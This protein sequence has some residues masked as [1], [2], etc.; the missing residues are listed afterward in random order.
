MVMPDAR[1]GFPCP[2]CGFELQGFE[3]FCPACGSPFALEIEEGRRARVV[4]DPV[5][6]A[7][8]F[9]DVRRSFAGKLD[10]RGVI[11]GGERSVVYLASDLR[12]DC[13]VALKVLRPNLVGTEFG[14]RFLREIEITQ[15]LHH[16]GVMMV[17]DMGT[18]PS[19]TDTATTYVYF[20]LQYVQ[21]ETLR[22]RLRRE[23]QLPVDEA[24]RIVRELAGALHYAH[25][26]QV[27]HRDVKPDNV[28]LTADGRVLLS[29]FGVA[30]GVEASTNSRLTGEGFILGTAAYLSP[31]AIAGDKQDAR[32][33]QYSLAC[34]L[35]ECLVGEAPF[36]G[37]PVDLVHKHIM[38]V[39]RQLNTLRA[40]I[41]NHVSAAVDRALSKLPADR[42][43]SVAAFRGALLRER[44]QAMASI[45][46]PLH[47]VVDPTSC[48]V[49]MPFG[50]LPGVQEL[51][52]DHVEPT[53][54]AC[55]LR[56]H[57]ADDIFGHHEI[58]RD[59]WREIGRARLLIADVT[60]RNP[61]VFYEL[62]MAHAIGKDVILLTQDTKD[63]P[64]DLTHLRHITYQY[65]PRGV[66]DFERALR[67]TIEAVLA[68]GGSG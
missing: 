65:S 19:T 42:F 15:S 32:S 12:R 4:A 36:G 23:R 13:M 31:E 63:V 43:S 34:V 6:A 9:Q 41:P 58:I 50:P 48:F 56:A 16:Q 10:V 37:N 7:S 49:I 21:G 25:E 24:L 51:Y 2:T 68:E 27:I 54:R 22:T 1:D 28:F 20:T 40:S 11:G 35:F 38:E 67:A 59:V 30:R 29:D 55:G 17:F 5:R 53:V 62:G 33:D 39:P 47:S 45:W 66:K 18:L 8:E 44:T 52:R 64:F 46:G 26:R 3:R 61:N 60:G 57:R 14:Q